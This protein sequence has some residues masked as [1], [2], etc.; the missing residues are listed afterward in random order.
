M[1]NSPVDHSALEPGQIISDHTYRLD[2]ETVAGYVDAV[3]DRSGPLPQGDG[4]GF[5]PP[6]AVAALGLRGVMD[7]LAVPPGTLHVGQDLEFVGAVRIGERLECRA[8]VLQ[9]SVRGGRRFFVVALSTQ[10]GEGRQVMRGKS[11]LLLPA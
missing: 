3:D 2:G 11:T 5:A 9:N 10:D 1:T 6:M 4:P 8:T 7:V